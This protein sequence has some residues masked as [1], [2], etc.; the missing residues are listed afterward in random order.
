M[1]L[2]EVRTA[3]TG[4]NVRFALVVQNR[5]SSRSGGVY[6]PFVVD[7]FVITITRFVPL[8]LKSTDA[9]IGVPSELKPD[10][11]KEK[12]VASATPLI[13]DSRAAIAKVPKLLL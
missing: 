11:V 6:A 5:P 10:P 3:E 7:V 9:E 8:T 12:G 4:V 13:P 2:P 1:T